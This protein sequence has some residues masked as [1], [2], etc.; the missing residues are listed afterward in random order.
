MGRSLSNGYAC[1]AEDMN[2][3]SDPSAI[4]AVPARV[5]MP[6]I[7]AAAFAAPFLLGLI[8]LNAI[9]ERVSTTVRP[10]WT[11]MLYASIHGAAGA[12][13]GI[14]STQ[15]TCLLNPLSTMT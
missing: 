7:F 3:R 11:Q 6:A 1:T 10:A 13:S 8:T 2:W 15:P 9:V 4:D 12:T 5:F 14:P